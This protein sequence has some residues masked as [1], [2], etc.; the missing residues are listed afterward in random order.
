MLDTG[1]D[2]TSAGLADGRI[3]DVI[4]ATGTSLR[5]TRYDPLMEDLQGPEMFRS[6]LSIPSSK[7]Q[8]TLQVRFTYLRLAVGL[9]P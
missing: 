6:K 8:G 3:V 4:D 7:R 5:H 1:V 9:W 2:V